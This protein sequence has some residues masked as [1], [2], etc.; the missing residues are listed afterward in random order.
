MSQSHTEGPDG[1]REFRLLIGGEWVPASDGGSF[2]NRNPADDADLVG[3]FAAATATDAAA[4]VDA[5]HGAFPAWRA[6]PVGKRAAVLEKAADYLDAHAQEFGAELTREEGKLAS[7][8]VAEVRRSA[9]TLRFYAVEGQTITGE[10]FP[11]DDAKMTVY[12]QREPLGVATVITPWNFPVSIPARKIAPALV[13][14]NTVVFKPSSEAPLI[15]LRLVEALVAGGLPAGVLNLVTGP[16]AA[17]GPA[18]TA[19][20]RVRAISFTGSTGAGRT[21]HSGLPMTTRTQM[22]LGGKNPLIVLADADL[23]EAVKLAIGGGFSLTGQACTG[24]SRVL[25]EK[26]VMAAFEERLK[27]ATE[28]LAVGPGTDPASKIGPLASKRQLESVMGYIEAG[29]REA[30]L[31]CG[32]QQLTGGAYD[33]GWYVA[34][35]VFADVAPDAVIAQEEIFGPVL[36]L[37]PVDGYEQAIE[38]ANGVEYGLS[39]ALAT[40]NFDY[41]QRFPADIEAGTVKVNRTTTGNLVNAPFGGVKASSTA[42]FRESGRAGLEFFTQLKTVYLGR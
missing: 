1:V 9:Q 24:T 10:V 28:A 4:A 8:G 38:V 6:T 15:G 17:S 42:T 11:Q 34:P 3:R 22:E 19:D 14:G 41:I 40:K 36:A 5:A 30:R 21:I 2:E 37:I 26:A 12:T 25:V 29:K 35:T 39:A 16:S 18:I 7:L 27:A 23:D 32:G 33:K 13:T 31:V 20:P